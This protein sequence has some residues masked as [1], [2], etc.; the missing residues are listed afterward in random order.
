M[1]APSR[2]SFVAIWVALAA[3]IV[4]LPDGMT[5]WFLPKDALL[6]IGAVLASL[7]PATG[8]L[9]RWFLI[10]VGAGVATLLVTALVSVSP[11]GALLGRFPRYEGFVSL[12]AYFAAAWIGARLL[13]Q[14]STR[15]AVLTFTRAAAVVAILLGFIGSLEAFGLRPIPS[16]LDR[17]GSLVGNATDQGIVG[18][19]LLMLLALPT[20]RAWR[21]QLLP[22]RG[23]SKTTEYLHTSPSDVLILTSGLVGAVLALV[24]SASRGA[25][26]AAAVGIVALVVVTIVAARPAG[27]PLWKPI[28]AG[29]SGLA[30]LAVVALVAPLTRSR[31]TGD[32]ALSSQTVNDRVLIWQE[33]ARLLAPNPLIGVGPSGYADA[34]AHAHTDEWFSTV[35]ALTTLDSPHNVIL[36]AW[37]AGGAVFVALALALVAVVAVSGVRAVRA[38][39]SGRLP[40]ERGGSDALTVPIR[41][42]LARADLLI[43]AI[44]A[45]TV[46]AAALLTHFTAAAT[47]ILGCLLVGVI[48]AASPV[49]DAR[50]WWRVVRTVLLVIWAGWLVA[51]ALAEVPMQR[52]IETSA[53]GDVVGAQAQFQT[54]VALRPW[55]A[56]LRS[57]AAQ[58]LAAAADGGVEGAAE[59]SLAWAK[60]ALAVIPDNVSTL[61]AYAVALQSTGDTDAAGRVIE[62]MLETRPDDADLHLRW[63]INAYLEEDINMA[64]ER[65]AEAQSLAP[66]DEGV[67]SFVTFLEDPASD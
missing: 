67:S 42:S 66:D 46:W 28:V 25:L 49:A 44:A 41:D 7:A 43:G 17:P 65:A 59:A 58:T 64:R 20:L 1:I 6:A 31:L 34:I 51:I 55:D 15:P 30:A 16:D 22:P 29:A 35:G 19:M 48:V 47:S 33:F 9:P 37:A 50:R 12:G 14:R 32:S 40:R 3:V 52:G 60:Q 62:R 21:P 18:A 13:G 5:R 2:W 23:R 63:A 38:S 56:D 36:Q 39:A 10:L 4:F 27:V 26:L 54:A 45:C 8:R 11:L 61:K 53:Q 24:L 57:I